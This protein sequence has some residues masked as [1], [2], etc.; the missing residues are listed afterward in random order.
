MTRE[1]HQQSRRWEKSLSLSLSLHSSLHPFFFHF[2]CSS[3]P[4]TPRH[5]HSTEERTREPKEA[6]T[7]TAAPFVSAKK[8][9]M[10]TRRR[11]KEPVIPV[12]QPRIRNLQS[13]RP[14]PQALRVC[15]SCINCHSCS[16][17]RTRCCS[18]DTPGRFPFAI[19]FQ[20]Q[21]ASAICDLFQVCTTG[22]GLF[23]ANALHAFFDKK[24]KRK[25]KSK[26]YAQRELN[27]S[28]IFATVTRPVTFDEVFPSTR[29]RFVIHSSFVILYYFPADGGRSIQ[30]SIPGLLRRFVPPCLS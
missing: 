20:L 2:Y 14:P 22:R 16:A 6:S 5:F 28:K 4:S 23:R 9:G 11:Q 3:L 25:K 26:I 7:Y 10:T 30:A 13:A 24:K 27:A 19:S 21:L 8:R 29:P 12:T 1:E 17:S 18:R 15:I